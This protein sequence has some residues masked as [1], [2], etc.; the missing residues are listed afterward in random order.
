MKDVEFVTY[1]FNH[2]NFLNIHLLHAVFSV[3]FRNY[4]AVTHQAVLAIVRSLFYYKI[5]K[6]CSET[7]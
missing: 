3:Y 5:I 2:P 1:K 7:V 4:F 6:S